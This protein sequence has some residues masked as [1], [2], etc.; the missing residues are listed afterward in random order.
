MSK[1]DLFAAIRRDARDGMSGCALAGRYKISRCTVKAAL[2]SAWPQPRKPLPP[3]ASR[4]D[5]AATGTP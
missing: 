4:L 1:I 3:R 5:P 2:A